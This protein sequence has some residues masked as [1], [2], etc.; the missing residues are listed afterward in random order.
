MKLKG[1]FKEISDNCNENFKDT[2][3]TLCFL[4]IQK[5]KSNVQRWQA[6]INKLAEKDYK[7]YKNFIN[8][9]K[10][11]SQE[12]KKEIRKVYYNLL[13]FE[14]IEDLLEKWSKYYLRMSVD[15]VIKIVDDPDCK[16]ISRSRLR[17]S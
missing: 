15:K 9:L 16:L 5:L 4:Y 3:K 7:S 10:R 2:D 12:L 17:R 13:H 6:D 14:N 11:E 1:L 8:L